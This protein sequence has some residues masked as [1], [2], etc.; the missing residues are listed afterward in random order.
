M[1]IRR[2]TLRLLP[3]QVQ[4]TA[5]DAVRRSHCE[6]YNAA[7]QERQDAWRKQQVSIGWMEQSQSLTEI[8][9]DCPEWAMHGRM[10]QVQTLVR[11]DRAYAAFFRRVKEGQN[12]GYPRFKSARRFKG[13]S[14]VRD[15]FR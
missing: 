6:L 13:W 8:R 12:P 3:S 2:C 15:G 9:R 11:L 7:L 4:H 10:T 14:H 1:V 5:M